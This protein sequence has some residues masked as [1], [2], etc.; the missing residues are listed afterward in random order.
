MTESVHSRRLFLATFAALVAL[1]VALLSTARLYP[2]IDLPDHLAAATIARDIGN[3][4]NQF[5]RY[6]AVQPFPLPNT[7]HLLFCGLTAFP[8]VEFANRLFFCLYAVLLPLSVL[9]IIRRA[10]GNEWFSLFSFLLMYNV[11]VTWGFVGFALG[12]PLVLIFYRFFILEPDGMSTPLRTLLAAG[13]LALLFFVHVLAA[14]FAVLLLGTSLAWHGRRSLRRLASAGVAAAPL[15]ILVWIWW[16]SRGHAHEEV[17][18]WRFLAAYYRHAFVATLPKRWAVLAFDNAPLT[19]GGPGLAIALAFS[20]SIVVPGIALRALGAH[21]AATPTEETAR[22]AL[23]RQAS[24]ERS[25]DA[26]VRR[27]KGEPS[28]L[29]APLLVCSLLCVL[30]LPNEIPRQQILFER[31]APFLL[32]SVAIVSSTIAVGR[33]RG[34]LAGALVALCL[35]HLALWA[36]YVVSFNRENATFSARFLPDPAGGKK[37]AGL[38]YDY[39]YRGRPIYIHFPS[40]YTA[41]KKGIAPTTLV[42]YRFG[43]VRRRASFIELPRYLEWVGRFDNYDGR[44]ANMDFILVRGALPPS[45]APFLKGFIPL[46]RSGRWSLYERV[47]AGP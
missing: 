27:K 20:L 31:F 35:V 19:A 12:I 28:T 32:L 15:L 21:R 47:P 38:I 9:L 39:T 1:H 14:L 8:S 40:Y 6:Y 42:E 22:P 43:A 16:H 37:L 13:T 45:A 25:T 23:E 36:S 30:V 4:S 11:D 18:L 44:Y 10:G 26:A 29:V 33:G 34:V 24:V 3:G 7:F 5:A 46:R 2:F 17:S 41:W